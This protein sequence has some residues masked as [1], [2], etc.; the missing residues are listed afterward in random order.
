MLDLPFESKYFGQIETSFRQNQMNQKPASE[1]NGSGFL[2]MLF[3]P[4]IVSCNEC[5]M[6]MK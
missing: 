6:Q 2:M 4:L 5:Y 1:L 3:L